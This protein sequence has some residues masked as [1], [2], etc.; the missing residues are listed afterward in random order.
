MKKF[1]PLNT[2][3]GVTSVGVQNGK[4]LVEDEIVK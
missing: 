4:I 2:C 3:W 1:T